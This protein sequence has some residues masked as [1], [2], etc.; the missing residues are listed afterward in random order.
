[1]IETVWRDAFIIDRQI[2]TGLG[3]MIN[4]GIIEQYFGRIEAENDPGSGAVFNFR[5]PIDGKGQ[6]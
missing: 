5:L 2:G 1:V 4:R 6:E 3:L